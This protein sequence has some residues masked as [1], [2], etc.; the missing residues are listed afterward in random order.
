MKSFLQS[1]EWAEI[2]ERDGRKAH[3]LVF[4][5]ESAVF[6]KHSLPL[7]L[8]YWYAPRPEIKNA[9][10]FLKALAELP[11][12]PVFVR[13]EPEHDMA[14][15]KGAR[16]SQNLQPRETILADLTK[17]DQDLLAAMHSK[18]RYNIRLAEKHGVEIEK[19]VGADAVD[20]FYRLL[21]HTAERDRFRL[22]P[23]THYEHLLQSNS[24]EFSNEL[25]F[26]IYNSQIAAAAVINFYGDTAT[27]LHSAS[28]YQLR[29]VK[30][31][32]LLH[33]RA[34]QAARAWGCGVFDFGG[35]DEKRWPGVTNFK[36]GFG[37]ERKSYPAA[38]DVVFRPVWRGIYQL[39][40]K[41][42]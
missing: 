33:W 7:G 27:C 16:T 42:V 24:H 12:Y 28:D 9:D 15:L 11:G 37:G 34:L 40:R 32:H 31:Q 21:Q 13:F 10:A 30:A 23:K 4:G 39:A 5:S 25:L 8:F 2:Q 3:R 29:N 1:R 38:F 6:F 20:D 41:V 17:S 14:P 18:T 22:H 19:R 35:I 26:A 36:I